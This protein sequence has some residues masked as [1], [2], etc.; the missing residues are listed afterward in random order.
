M[1]QHD[2]QMGQCQAIFNS[3]DSERSEAVSESSTVMGELE[4]LIAAANHPQLVAALQSLRSEA[5]EPQLNSVEQRVGGASSTG[6]QVL[7][8]MSQGDQQMSSQSQSA[9][10]QVPSQL[11]MPGPK[12]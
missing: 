5:F 3:V 2:V 10:G 6:N 7:G 4:S 1:G 12:G 9:Q 8:L 11:D